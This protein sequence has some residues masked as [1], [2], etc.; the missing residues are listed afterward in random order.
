MS[1][2]VQLNPGDV[3]YKFVLKKRIGAGG[4]GDVWLAHDRTIS[5]EVAVKVLDEGVTIDERLSEARIGNHLDHANLV[6]MHYADVV[7]HNGANL[8]IIAMD[9]HA[10]GSILSEINSGNFL[11]IPRV[12][13]F[14]TNILRGLEYLH[15]LNFYH[16]DIK[17]GNILIGDAGQGVLTDY[18]IT[19]HSPLGQPVQPRNAYILH[20]A[21]EILSCNEINIQTDVYQTGFTAFR[22]LNGL[23][24]IR[25]K[26]C[27]LGQVEYYKLV[28]EGKVI[29][30]KDYQP[31]IPRNL[32]TVISRA[33]NVDPSK[34]YQSAV[35]MRRA[36]ERL[37]Y[38]GYWTTDARGNLVGYNRG[39]EFRFEERAKTLSLFAFT[40]FKKNK[41]S[42]RETKIGKLSGKDLSSKQ[43]D[44]AKRRF[45]QWVVTGSK[46]NSLKPNSN[47]QY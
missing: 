46:C 40:A 47:Q 38:P 2:G 44:H 6:K 17:P 3:L 8:V 32:K 16:S 20:M 41:D 21:P 28:V 23:G 19:C 9:Y 36:L 25:D 43:R 10:G 12:I 14:V 18:G 15:E 29:R 39:Y 42:G 31:F 5:R 27:R 13:H 1:Q 33:V 26:L 7:Q 24:L 4:F 11:P 34:R 45:M 30:S 22:L 35:D 37:S